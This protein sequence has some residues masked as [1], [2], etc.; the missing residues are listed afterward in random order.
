IAPWLERRGRTGGQAALGHEQRV[1]PARASWLSGRIAAWVGEE[2]TS[3]AYP[4]LSL[5]EDVYAMHG[6]FIDLFSTI[7][8]FE[9]LG[10]AITSRVISGG[11]P[12]HAG[13]DDFLARL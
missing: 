5:R 1:A 13:V 8:T 11:L 10:A 7:P 6:N 12:E 9:R 2:R 3:V 4:G